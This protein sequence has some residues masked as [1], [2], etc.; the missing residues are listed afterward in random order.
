MELT[1]FSLI[2]SFREANFR[3]YCQALQE[4]LP[5]F[6]ANNNVNYA[7]WLPIHLKDML[8]LEQKHPAIATEFHNGKFVVHKS[9][10]KFS[11][12]AIDQAHEQ[13][14]AIIKGD[15]GAIGITEDPSALRRWMVAGPEVSHLNAQ[16]ESLSEVQDANEPTQ[17]HEQT[18]QFQKTFLDRVNKLHSVMLEMGNPFMDESKELVTLDTKNVAHPT[19]A[20]LVA[21]HHEKGKKSFESFLKSFE[22]GEQC[23]FYEPI[24]KNKTD[25][26]RQQPEASSKVLK[27]K[28][29]KDD[30]LLFSKLFISCQS[31][32]CDLQEFFQHENQSFP[33][34]LSDSGNLY[35]C[36]K[37]QLASILEDQVSLPD[38]EPNVEAIIVDG[39]AFVNSVQPRLS[40]TFEEY[41]TLEIIPKIETFSSKYQR[42]DIVFDIY[43]TGSLKAET[44]SRRGFGARRR[45]TDKG[46]IPQNWQSFLRDNTN[47]TEL[48]SFL[49]DKIVELCSTNIVIVTRLEGVVCNRPISTEGLAPCNHEEADTRIFVHARH[50]VAEGFRSI[51]I[52]AN[53]TDIL[54]ISVSVLSSFQDLGLQTLW[55]DFGQ[56]KNQRWIPIHDICRSIGYGKSQGIS[57][58]HAFTGCD[59]VSAFRG[60]GK[61]TAW[62]TWNVCPEVTSV[63]A[64][65]SKYP[66]VINDSDQDILEMYVIAM[67]DK[68]SPTANINNARLDLF[69]RKQ[70]SYESIPPTRGA[71]I[72]HTRRA[73]YQAGC[74]WGQ[75]IISNMETECPGE[76]GWNKMGDIWQIVW[77]KLAPI[78]QS[79]Q[80]LTKCGCKT[81]CCGRCKCFRLSLPCTA[82]CSCNCET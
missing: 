37:S 66:P 82:L 68:S 14:N 69:A 5:Y 51:M 20:E 4:L 41:A 64:K 59:I 45:V 35:S 32:E 58:F 71:L 57:F 46:K 54:V 80:Q 12:L 60:K 19:A 50:A 47:K 78:A 7:R 27:Q 52:K 30:C 21:K 25:F 11:A 72:E 8:C 17:H 23:R 61:K 26:F 38:T 81:E 15:G 10:R 18:R 13:A 34:A 42:T 63:F 56:G 53:D 62:Q 77:T 67:Y 22:N 31:R 74:I 48:F 75:S 76:W 36:Q 43:R 28:N 55:I 49:A 79:C 9:V 33:A 65:L 73:A 3:L 1:I 16:Y 70:R 40:K 39:S 2:R 24:K 6:F 29:I 44:R